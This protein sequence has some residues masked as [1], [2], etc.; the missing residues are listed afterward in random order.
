MQNYW[1]PGEEQWR[2]SHL[3]SLHTL[4]NVTAA[5]HQLV[6]DFA[7]APEIVKTDHTKQLS[8]ERLLLRRL[9]EELRSVELLAERGHGFQAASAAATLFEQAHF[10]NYVSSDA[11][12]ADA[13]INWSDPHYSKKVKEVVTAS[14]K[15]HGWD[16]DRTDDEYAKYRFLCGFKHN[17][18]LFMKL[19]QLP[20]D[21]DQYLGRL[22]LADSDWFILITVGTLA[23]RRLVAANVPPFIERCNQL[24]DSVKAELDSL[25]KITTSATSVA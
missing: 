5:I 12:A 15:A 3:E 13:F 25:P 14:G 4:L 9:G 20:V 1:I 22:A 10:L 6:A 8:V 7:T 17:N 23:M 18:P 2:D 24:M 16:Q 19:L 11:L 21:P